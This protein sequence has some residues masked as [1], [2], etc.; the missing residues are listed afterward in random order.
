MTS[1]AGYDK[2]VRYLDGLSEDCLILLWS[3]IPC[4]G[5]SSWASMNLHR[6][7]SY[8]AKLMKHRAKFQVLFTRFT[9]LARTVLGRR[10]HI[11]MEWPDN[12]NYVLE[13]AR[14]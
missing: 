11:A 7:R 10:G 13:P 8:R 3:G 5:G 4:T 1:D 9:Q 6:F 2:I 14:C 12:N